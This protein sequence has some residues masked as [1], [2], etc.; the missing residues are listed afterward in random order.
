MIATQHGGGPD[1]RLR[2][3]MYVSDDD[4]VGVD[5]GGWV[6]VRGPVTKR[7]HRHLQRLSAF[8]E[9]FILHDATTHDFGNNLGARHVVVRGSSR[10]NASGTTGVLGHV[11]ATSWGGDHDGNRLRRAA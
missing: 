2:P 4:G 9:A 5:E 10:G 6:D 7:I 8:V 11:H 3:D 1:A